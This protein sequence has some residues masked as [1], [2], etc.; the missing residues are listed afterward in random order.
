[1]DELPERIYR[2]VR[3]VPPGKV[4]TYGQLAAMCGLSDSRIVGDV[5]NASP[6]D[7]PW[8][9][10][11]NSRGAISIG[12]ATGMRQRALLEAEG[13]EFDE[14]GRVQ[15]AEVGWIPDTEWL[16]AQ[17]YRPPPPLVKDRGADAGD[18]GQQLSLF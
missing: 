13:V 3:A 18:A 7:V 2:L 14:T 15:F 10:V 6:R 12:G 1:M 17:G 11:I 5:M 9:R 16:A 8:Q 4:T